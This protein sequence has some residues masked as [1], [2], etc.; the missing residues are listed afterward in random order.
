MI[1]NYSKNIWLQQLPFLSLLLRDRDEVVAEEDPTYTFDL[2]ELPRQRRNR[3]VSYVA[4]VHGRAI[5][6][7]GL[8]RRELETAWVRC[9][10]RLDKEHP[11]AEGHQLE[12][13]AA[14]ERLLK[15]LL[16]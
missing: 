8:A 6:S 5:A 7:H 9:R 10:T 16:G 13:L 12:P 14:R 3:C 1:S 15:Y 4:K 2:K 11:H